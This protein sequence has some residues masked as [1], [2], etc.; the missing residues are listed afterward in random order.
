MAVDRAGLV[1][2]RVAEVRG[3]RLAR[4]AEEARAEVERADAAAEQARLM[5]AKALEARTE[6][7]EI[8]TASPA[9]AQARL[10]L[11]RTIAREAGAVAQAADRA[12]RLDLARDA[13]GVA[14]EAV[15]RHQIRSEVIA[16]HQRTLQRAEE[17]RAED[18]SE[19]DAPAVMRMRLS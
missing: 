6:A 11:D 7:R 4:A 13:H 9:C 19:A 15:V 5:R 18:R 14:I 1:L 12:A 17:R 10:W 16:G 3:K 8:F 2:T